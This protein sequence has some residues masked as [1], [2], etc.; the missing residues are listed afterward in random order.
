MVGSGFFLLESYGFNDRE[1]IAL[2]YILTWEISMYLS[3]NRI[4]H[5]VES[6]IK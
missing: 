3:S 6:V 5:F 2:F 4:T 1:K